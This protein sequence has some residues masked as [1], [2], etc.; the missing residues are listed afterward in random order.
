MR[1]KTVRGFFRRLPAVFT[2][3]DEQPPGLKTLDILIMLTG[4]PRR[5]MN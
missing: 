5:C 1:V 3:N 4:C 2:L